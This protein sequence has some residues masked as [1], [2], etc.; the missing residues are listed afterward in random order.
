[1]SS[2]DGSEEHPQNS[3]I[4]ELE[5]RLQAAEQQSDEERADRIR[6][7]LA[8]ENLAKEVEQLDAQQRS[9]GRELARRESIIDDYRQWRPEVERDMA[10]LRVALAKLDERYA[11]RAE[12]DKLYAPKDGMKSMPDLVQKLLAGAAALFALALVL[13]LGG[14]DLIAG[15]MP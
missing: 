8:L 15:M 11:S 13:A 7:L 6:V 9:D 14:K 1:M 4:G 5:T 2:P 12:L 10:N 3:R